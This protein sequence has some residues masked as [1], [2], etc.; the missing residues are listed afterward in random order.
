MFFGNLRS[1]APSGHKGTF[2]TQ[3]ALATGRY[4]SDGLCLEQKY[5][6]C[7]VSENS[8]PWAFFL[9]EKVYGAGCFALQ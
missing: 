1:K 5:S 4:F 3:A 6:W 8:S 7:H 9:G 2:M